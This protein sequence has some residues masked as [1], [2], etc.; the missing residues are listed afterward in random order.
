MSYF[1][2]VYDN[3]HDMDEDDFDDIG[4]FNSEP[5][6]LI[7]AQRRVKNEVIHFWS[8]GTQPDELVSHWNSF[9]NDPTICSTDFNI[10]AAFFSGRNYAKEVVEKLKE[11]LQDDRENIQ[12]VYQKTIL[13]AAEKHAKINQMIP[14]TSIPYAVHLSNVSM[15]IMLAYQKTD[16]F[17]LKLA[18]QAALL[19]DTLE[20]TYLH[21]TEDELEEKF[22]LA[23][24]ACVKALT[25]NTKLPKDQLMADSLNR[26]KKMPIEIWAVKL[27]DRITNLQPPPV[28]WDNEKK[29]AYREEAKL[30]L[31]ELKAGNEY[32][33][34]RLETKI[35]EYLIYI[36]K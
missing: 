27:A 26:I 3:F 11:S 28:H 10:T 25:K 32:L 7:E 19:H 1:L 15:E 21:T 33:A 2:R 4:S 36:E 6:A 24:L 35:E 16:N 31:N 13:F 30:I 14:G 22:G 12:S 8:S 23:I 5:D 29:V 9:G 20:D 34:K 18:I 17:N